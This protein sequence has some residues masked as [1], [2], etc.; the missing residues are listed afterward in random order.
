MIQKILL[1]SLLMTSCR[2]AETVQMDLNDV[3]FF[4]A[5]GNELGTDDPFTRLFTEYKQSN[6]QALHDLLEKQHRMIIIKQENFLKIQ[7]I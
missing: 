4:T 5:G 6:P 7:L 1:F 3:R 2:A